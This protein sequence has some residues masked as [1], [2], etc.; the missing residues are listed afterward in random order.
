[1]AA[2]RAW[3][4][5]HPPVDFDRRP[6]IAVAIHDAVYPILQA[7]AWPRWL[8]LERALLDGS[9]TGDL[10]FSALVIRTMCEE[11][12]R[13]HSLDL[14]A[15]E[16]RK[17]AASGDAADQRRFMLFLRMVRANLDEQDD[18]RGFDRSRWSDLDCTAISPRQLQSAKQALNDYVHP[19]YGSHIAA[20]YPERAEAGRIILEGIIAA[21]D[22]FF[23]FSWAEQPLPGRG[24][25]IDVAPIES[26]QNTV[27]RFTKQVLPRVRDEVLRD[28]EAGRQ[29]PE[30][31]QYYEG[32][33]VVA[34]V[35]SKQADVEGV[36]D[37]PE[38]AALVNSLR[39]SNDVQPNKKPQRGSGCFRLWEGAGEQ[40][41]LLLAM[42]RKAEQDLTNTFPKGM[43]SKSEQE[44]WLRFQCLALA[45][46]LCLEEVKSAA[47]KTQL[48]RQTVS[49]NPLG[50][51]LCLR[52]LIEHRA[53]AEWPV[54]YLK[55]EWAEIGKRVK[56]GKDLPSHA[57]TLERAL[58]RFLA[59]TKNSVEASLPWTNR[60]I[61]GRWTLHLSLPD[62]VDRAFKKDDL[63]RVIYDIASATL[64]GRSY[65][66]LDL[67]KKK[68]EGASLARL[69]IRVLEGLCDPSAK[70]DLIAPA[71]TLGMKFEHAASLGGAATL[72]SDREVKGAFSHIEDKEKLRPERDYKG[73]GSKENPFSF[74]RHLQFD[75]ASYKLLKQRG[76]E[77]EKVEGELIKEGERFLYVYRLADREWWFEL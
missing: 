32:R 13:L 35:T 77:I 51:L 42:A 27:R 23:A 37:D 66:G 7:A 40:D 22:A 38:I 63:R 8:L 31:L 25:P 64:H 46:A 43:P 12:Q 15:S 62:A 65:R 2:L 20:L 11:V 16:I 71:I 50:I 52:S 68:G 17:L 45:L 53:V 29:S 76:I 61:N 72:G 6:S 54:R 26:W 59:G 70:M 55:F 19:N 60:E 56:P 57:E 69:S 44:R 48:I 4:D 75:V 21:Y 28:I 41:I 34:S 67:L 33:A 30:S 14:D 18:P 73:D 39:F 74:Q 47:L 49:R 3:T 58:A 9:Q 36:L 1:M 24:A 10:S 5:D